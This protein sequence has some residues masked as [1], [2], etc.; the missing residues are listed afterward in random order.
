MWYVL[1][2]VRLGDVDLRT[3]QKARS[4]YRDPRASVLVEDG[5]QHHRL[6]GVLVRGEAE[7]TEDVEQ[8]QAIGLG[9]GGAVRG[10]YG[11]PER[12]AAR[13]G[14]RRSASASPCPS[15]AWSAELRK[16]ERVT[17]RVVPVPVHGT[18]LTLV[19]RT[20]MTGVS[21]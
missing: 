17:W 4:L 19:S 14:R 13:R 10:P 20:P 9:T 3:S 8:V 16:A 1:R 7:L 2:P 18:E 6:R 21:P 11:A 12:R 5:E 15:G